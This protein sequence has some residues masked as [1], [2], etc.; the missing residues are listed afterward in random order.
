MKKW[1]CDNNNESFI[2][3]FI[4]IG[5]LTG[6]RM[7]RMMVCF[8]CVLLFLLPLLDSSLVSIRCDEKST[9]F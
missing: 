8:V 1:E 6:S 3:I 7:G 4:M 9:D 5:A 2:T